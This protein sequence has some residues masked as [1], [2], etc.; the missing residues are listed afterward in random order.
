MNRPIPLGR[1][2]QISILRR[3]IRGGARYRSAQNPEEP[4][5]P[6][7]KSAIAYSYV[8]PRGAGR[9]MVA[10]V[11]GG[12]VAGALGSTIAGTATRPDEN[13]IKT[14]R[15]AYLGVFPDEVVVFRGK[16][17]A[18]KPKPTSEVLATVPRSTIASARLDRK[19]VKGVMTVTFTDG[20]T[21][22]FDTPRFQLKAAE[23]VVA[24]LS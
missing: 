15:F 7:L 24:A 13:P 9:Q 11:A 6:D 23:S 14:G 4:T 10:R 1:S 16:Q 20:E 18:F 8:E 2:H 19:A 21:W 3:R 22:E 5:V 17:G 12:K